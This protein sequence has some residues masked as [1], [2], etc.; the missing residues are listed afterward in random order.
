MILAVAYSMKIMPFV[1]D[2]A[3]Q[4]LGSIR[5]LAPNRNSAAPNSVML[6]RAHNA[7]RSTFGIYAFYP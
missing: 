3:Y 1:V 6:T 2:R 7:Q 4:T 5:D